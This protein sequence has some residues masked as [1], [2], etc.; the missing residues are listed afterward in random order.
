M[1]PKKYSAYFATYFCS[2]NLNAIQLLFKIQMYLLGSQSTPNFTIMCLDF[3][4]SEN[5]KL[6]DRVRFYLAI[7]E[8]CYLFYLSFS[9]KSNVQRQE[10]SLT[11]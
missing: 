6:E 3:A 7:L 8:Q 9:V 10:F 4:Y 1:L 11:F 5:E 2:K